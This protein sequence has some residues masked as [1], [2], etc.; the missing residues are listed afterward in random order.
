MSTLTTVVGGLLALVVYFLISRFATLFTMNGF[1]KEEEI[2]SLNKDKAHSKFKVKYPEADINTSKNMAMAF[3]FIFAFGTSIFAFNYANKST[4]IVE[5]E[6]F[7][8]ETDFEAEA[9]QTEQVKP[10]PP[11]P[12]PPPEIEV[13]D[14]DEVIK[15]ETPLQDTEIEKDEEVVVKE[16]VKKVVE[17]EEAEPA[18]FLVVEDMPKYKGCEGLKGDEATQCTM[19]AIMKYVGENVEYPR[20]A[21]S[22]DIEGKVFVSFVVDKD[23]SVTDVQVVRGVDK[24]LDNAAVKV[25]K[26]LPKFTPGKQRGKAARVKYNIPIVF[27][28]S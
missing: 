8:V 17:E 2:I 16:P 25:V 24:D 20:V 11:P 19:K 5:V 14:D 12:P 10:P 18:F 4:K 21:E 9:P 15:D 6:K 3:A 1:K 7:E 13:V 26:S 22:N 28:L 23:G 27:K